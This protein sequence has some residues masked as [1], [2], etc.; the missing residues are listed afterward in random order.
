MAEFSFTSLLE[1][2]KRNRSVRRFDASRQIPDNQLREII[3]A[4]RYCASGR[5]LQ[6]LKYSVISEPETCEA[7]FPLLKWA[8]YLTDWDGPQPDERPV[9]YAIQLLDKSI[10]SALLCDDGLQLEA[11]TLAACSMGINSCIIKSFDLPQLSRLLGLPESLE[12]RYVVALGY[13][14]E[15]VRLE[16][17]IDDDYKYWR[18]ADGVHHTPKR[19]LDEILISR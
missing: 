4:T 13:P 2:L 12:P 19:P 17:M 6:P 8:G 5:N 16:E 10:T 7:I 15:T 1:L 18:S 9:A 11:L 3:D 14:A